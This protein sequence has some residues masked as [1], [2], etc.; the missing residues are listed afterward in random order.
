MAGCR[1]N[2][3][4]RER[5]GVGDAADGRGRPDRKTAAPG[6]F[7]IRDADPPQRGAGDL[8]AR[9]EL[10]RAGV[11]DGLSVRRF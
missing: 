11:D 1:A 8:A 9:G 10:Q 3:R 7:A 2:D 5:P 4:G 6:D